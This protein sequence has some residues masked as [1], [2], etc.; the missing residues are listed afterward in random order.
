MAG[1]E[2]I[3]GVLYSPRPRSPRPWAAVFREKL[4]PLMEPHFEAICRECPIKQHVLSLLDM[5]ARLQCASQTMEGMQVLPHAAA[6]SLAFY[7]GSC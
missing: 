5:N 3:T 6:C 7:E 2:N 1:S 4:F